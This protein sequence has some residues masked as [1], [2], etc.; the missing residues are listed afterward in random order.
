MGDAY[1]EEIRQNPLKLRAQLQSYAACDDLAIRAVVA[2]GFGGL[3]PARG[4]A[5]RCRI[6][7]S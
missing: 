7:R 4:P 6:R 2:E 5:H 3:G 1:I